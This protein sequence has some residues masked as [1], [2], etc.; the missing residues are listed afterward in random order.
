MRIS[1]IERLKVKIISKLPLIRSLESTFEYSGDSWDYKKDGIYY[2]VHKGKIVASGRQIRFI[3]SE[4]WAVKNEDV[5]SLIH[6][7]VEVASGELI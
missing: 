4:R 5:W 6:K 7:G 2:L 1:A 3:D